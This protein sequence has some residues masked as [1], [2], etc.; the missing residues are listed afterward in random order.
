MR[1]S[2][3]LLPSGE[4]VGGGAA[5]MRGLGPHLRRAKSDR[6]QQDVGVGQ[7]GLI[8]RS[9]HHESRLLQS[10]VTFS[11]PGVMKLM[12]AAVQFYDESNFRAGEVADH[13]A[14]WRLTTK[15][16][17][18]EAAVANNSPKYC[19]GMG[20]RSALVAGALRPVRRLPHGWPPP[21]PSACGAHLLPRGEKAIGWRG[22]T[23][24][25]KP[26]GRRR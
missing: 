7:E 26:G 23:P 1:K 6:A 12:N 15:L 20:E 16:E 11:I 10:G 19:L 17:V 18:I 9:Q 8:A 3:V 22:R 4:K 14:D 21:H 24:S 5:R 13:A 2:C 25:Q